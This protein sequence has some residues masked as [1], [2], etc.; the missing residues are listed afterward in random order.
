[1]SLLTRQHG[2]DNQAFFHAVDTRRREQQL[3]WPALARV[4]WEQSHALNDRRNDHPISPA[5]IRKMGERGGVSCQHALFLLRWLGVPPETFIAEPKPGTAGIAL[6]LADESQRLRWNLGKLYTALK[7]GRTK[8][9][10]T[11]LQAAKH[12]HCTPSQLTGLRT[13][14]FATGMVLAMGITQALHRPAADFVYAA[15]W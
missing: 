3:S 14:K 9:G 12:L 7:H 13:A 10:A 2:F 5:T 15:N 6:P 11:W 8:R 1:M 4:V